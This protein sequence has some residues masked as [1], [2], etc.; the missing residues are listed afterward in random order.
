VALDIVSSVLSGF[1]LSRA[2]AAAAVG[3]FMGTA[4]AQGW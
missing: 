4:A 2:E 3:A 1:E